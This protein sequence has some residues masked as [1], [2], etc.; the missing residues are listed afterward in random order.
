MRTE[1]E[2]LAEEEKAVVE[3]PSTPMTS[4]FGLIPA[5]YTDGMRVAKVLAT[6]NFVPKDFKGKPNDILAAMMLG[7]S[8]G[9]APLQALQG[10]AV[11]NGR[12]TIWGDAALAV[13]KAHPDYEYIHENFDEQKME[14]RCEMKRK[15]E[16]PAV[17]TFNREDAALAGLRYEDPATGVVKG[18]DVWIKYEKRMLKM[19]ARGF[20]MRDCMPDALKGLGIREE[21]ID[22]SE[23]GAIEV[24]I[25]PEIAMPKSL[26]EQ[27]DPAERMLQNASVLNSPVIDLTH[28]VVSA[29]G[30]V[31][32]D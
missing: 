26:P 23:N 2:N 30:E 10:I 15:G 28:K 25:E 11:I 1:N 4:S 5:T 6:S 9:L 12:P 7:A 3:Q 8:V 21:V 27:V 32:D 24:D 29:P 16:D 17:Q 14:A 22:Y 19:R 18:K 20:C 13:C 31:N